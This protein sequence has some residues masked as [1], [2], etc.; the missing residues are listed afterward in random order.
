MSP[1]RVSGKSGALLKRNETVT[2]LS[3]VKLT[4]YEI[5]LYADNSKAVDITIQ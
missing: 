1:Y 4:V 5:K 3:L 2:N